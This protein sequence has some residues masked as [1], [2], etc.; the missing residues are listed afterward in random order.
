MWLTS[1][2]PHARL[3][4]VIPQVRA[5][6]RASFAL[7]RSHCQ[8]T[9]ARAQAIAASAN[10][11]LPASLISG[12]GADRRPV[13]RIEGTGVRGPAQPSAYTHK[14]IRRAHACCLHCTLAH[15]RGLRRNS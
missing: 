14:R 2:M 12:T 3:R 13:V 6:A 11:G 9:G 10:F 4:D 8:M 7:A 5:R 1:S 15:N